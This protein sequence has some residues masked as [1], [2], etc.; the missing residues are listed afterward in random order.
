MVDECKHNTPTSNTN[1]KKK[2]S[3]ESISRVGK[4]EWIDTTIVYVQLS[5]VCIFNLEI[6]IWQSNWG[7]V[8]GDCDAIHL[9]IIRGLRSYRVRL[10]NDDVTAIGMSCSLQES[11]PRL[12]NEGTTTMTARCAPTCSQALPVKPRRSGPEVLKRERGH[13]NSE[14]GVAEVVVFG[15]L[16]P[17]VPEKGMHKLHT[18]PSW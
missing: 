14:S 12:L 4:R 7:N 9:H 18:A 11:I 6:E 16:Q 2:L 10:F 13:V 1:V 8:R 15:A 3:N 5:E 17:N